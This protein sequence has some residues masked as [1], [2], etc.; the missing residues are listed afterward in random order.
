MGSNP[1]EALIII[2]IFLLVCILLL[3]YDNGYKTQWSLSN[4]R[5]FCELTLFYKIQNQIVYI[6]FPPELTLNTAP[7]RRLH[8]LKFNHLACKVNAYKCSFFNRSI[9]AWNNLP[10][11][12]VH[13]TSLEKFQAAV[14][15]PLH[16]TTY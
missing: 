13:A 10:A 15:L 1:I 11:N 4:R 7:T 14:Q 5:L 12:A 6:S 3:M 8:N 9:P 16:L 2:I